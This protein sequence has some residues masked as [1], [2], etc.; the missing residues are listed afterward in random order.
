VEPLLLQGDA[1]VGVIWT[2]KWRVGYSFASAI[3][4]AVDRA[5]TYAV[6]KPRQ[7]RCW[8]EKNKK[9]NKLPQQQTHFP[10][11]WFQDKSKYLLMYRKDVPIRI[12]GKHAIGAEAGAVEYCP[13][14]KKW[15]YYWKYHCW[16]YYTWL[17]AR[18]I[19]NAAL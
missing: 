4:L 1:H 12:E 3:A 2:V 15:E 11:G 5:P 7:E 17:Q 8:E 6:F 18:N 14:L 16:M 19:L 9:G 13:P 10:Y